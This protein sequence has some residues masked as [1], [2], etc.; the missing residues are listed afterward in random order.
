MAD[1]V[2]NALVIEAEGDYPLTIRDVDAF[3]A[4]LINLVEI[5]Q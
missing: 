5:A 2:E 4:A 3:V 1:P